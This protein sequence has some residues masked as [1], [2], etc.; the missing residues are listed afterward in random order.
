MMF[1]KRGNRCVTE[2]G[3]SIVSEY[4]MA[5]SILKGNQSKSL[6]FK[7]EASDYYDAKY[8]TCTSIDESMVTDQC[9]TTDHAHTQEDYQYVVDL[10]M[11][12][13]RLSHD[14]QSLKRLEQ[15][16]EFFDREHHILF[17]IQ[18]YGLISQFKNDNVVWGVGRGSSCASYVLFLLEVHD[19]NPVAFDI[20][21]SEMS[22]ET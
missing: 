17:I 1:D 11:K 3:H 16:L 4:E 20:P 21:F 8:E 10:L 15:E 19:I 12:S 2:C 7:S 9:E 13:D 18:V 22:K 6:V 5:R 14:E